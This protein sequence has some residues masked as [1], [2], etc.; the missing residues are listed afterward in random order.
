MTAK[1]Q[2]CEV[3]LGPGP[4]VHL[5]ELTRTGPDGRVTER[6]TRWINLPGVDADL[7]LSPVCQPQSGQCNV[8]IFWADAE[9]SNP[10]SLILRMDG[11][12]LS[13][14]VAHSL[15]FHMKDREPHVLTAEATFPGGR[16]AKAAVTLGTGFGGTASTALTAVPV[17]ARGSISKIT[18][19]LAAGGVGVA[20]VERGPSHVVFVIEPHVFARS[21]MEFSFRRFT[22]SHEEWTRLTRPLING[23]TMTI[24]IAGSRILRVDTHASIRGSWFQQLYSAGLNLGNPPAM[25]G[26][27]VAVA[28]MLA[29]K[30]PGRR[31]VVLITDGKTPAGNGFPPATV[32]TYL[33]QIMVPLEVWHI[34][35]GNEAAWPGGVDIRGLHALEAAMSDLSIT[36]K[37]QAV[38]WI[39]HL[40]DPRVP[41][42]SLPGKLHIAGRQ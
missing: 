38:A 27:A 21:R 25:L 15:S 8:R 39:P 10:T 30:R 4:A 1:R 36:L 14:E 20:A 40:T 6:A 23:N 35:G 11:K 19:K 32:R 29:A 7:E 41:D 18:R 16:T 28:G 42:L 3:D 9:K 5:L 13:H 22:S 2:A 34:K 37:H 31:A 24:L 12:P 26:N 33:R 17:A